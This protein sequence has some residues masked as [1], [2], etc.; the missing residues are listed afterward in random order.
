MA[1][2]MRTV[3]RP[4]VHQRIMAFQRSQGIMAFPRFQ[5]RHE[6]SETSMERPSDV[7][8]EELREMRNK[9]RDLEGVREDAKFAARMWVPVIEDL[10]SDILFQH[11]AKLVVKQ[12]AE[13]DLEYIYELLEAKLADQ[14]E[15]LE[16]KLADQYED[17]GFETRCEMV[18]W[19]Q[20]RPVP[21][22]LFRMLS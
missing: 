3:R 1:F 16:A 12:A 11:G 2:M 17:F 21:A 7:I 10:A 15:I 13:T 18:Y 20:P 14:Y 22:L 8:Q 19:V 5:A 4:L 9:L 6:S